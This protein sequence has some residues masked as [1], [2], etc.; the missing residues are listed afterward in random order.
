MDI[1]EAKKLVTSWLRKHGLSNKV[2]A[3]TIDFSDLAR[4]SRIF[5]VVH[6]WAPGP[7]AAD[8]NHYAM[9]HGFLMEYRCLRDGA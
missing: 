8:L 7:I 1:R 4:C 6:D 3:K 9:Q 2:T 5:V